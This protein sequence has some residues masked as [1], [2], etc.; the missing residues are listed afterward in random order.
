MAGILIYTAAADSDGTLGGLVDLAKQES[1]ETIIRN[2][3]IQASV[4]SSDP[5]C[6]EHLPEATSLHAAACH[7]CAFV[8]ETS[9]ELGNRFL[10]RSLIVPTFLDEAMSI[11]DLEV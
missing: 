7:A 8:S 10:D 4:C 6:S 2:A 5:I 3:L 1:M 9:C 11:F